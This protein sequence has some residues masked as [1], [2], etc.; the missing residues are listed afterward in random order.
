MVPDLRDALDDARAVESEA[1]E[2]GFPIPSA[3]A[4]A[5]SRKLL[6]LLYGIRPCR[7]EVYPTPDGEV[8]ID[9]RWQA[10]S[11]L[12][13][14]CDSQGG[15]LCLVNNHGDNRRASYSNTAL[16]PDGFVREALIEL[17]AGE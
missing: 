15:A 17:T 13:L 11:S 8:A 3:L 7:F 14:L 6:P 4:L 10:G 12:L 1:I 9:A 16:L 2:E 5:N